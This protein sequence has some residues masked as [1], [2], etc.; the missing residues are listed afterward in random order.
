[1]LLASSHINAMDISRK[2][3]SALEIEQENPDIIHDAN[4]TNTKIVTYNKKNGHLLMWD[5]TTGRSE[6]VD[7]I[8][9]IN[10]GTTKKEISSLYFKENVILFFNSCNQK[11]HETC[12]NNPFPYLN[13]THAVKQTRS[14]FYTPSTRKRPRKKI[15][16]NDKR[17]VISDFTTESNG[18]TAEVSCLSL[19]AE[20]PEAY[21]LIEN[22][23]YNNHPTSVF[24]SDS[25]YV[26][27]KFILEEKESLLVLKDETN[28]IQKDTI[29]N[30]EV[31]IKHYDEGSFDKDTHELS[32][33]LQ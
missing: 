33:N 32:C 31:T 12:L 25:S 24:D 23:E 30:D 28:L 16:Q 13:N 21:I 3:K 17:T 15:V 19:R 7:K 26:S 18:H 14:K 4:L 5:V 1:M 6:I 22:N 29:T 8:S 11:I 20:L 10:A 27:E 9:V 2:Y